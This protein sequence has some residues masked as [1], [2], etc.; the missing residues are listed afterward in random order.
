VDFAK[1]ALD[2][3]R[4]RLR[5]E[6]CPMTQYKHCKVFLPLA[7][8]VLTL[9]GSRMQADPLDPNDFISL[10]PSPFIQA[11]TYTIDTGVIPVLTKPDS[12]TI[13]GVV[14]SDI[15]VFTFADIT[16]SSGITVNVTGPRPLAVLSYKS[17]HMTGG[18]IDVRGSTGGVSSGGSGGPG[19]GGGG[20]SL[21][22][23]GSGL[24]DGFTSIA[25][26]G[27]GGGGFGGSGGTGGGSGGGLGGTPYGNLAAWLEGGSSGGAGGTY[28]GGGGGGERWRSVP[29]MASPSAG[30]FWSMAGTAVLFLPTAAAAAGE[31]CCTE[32]R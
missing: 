6:K 20:N 1:A 25:D 27:G 28:G 8:L 26:D 7:T 17:V 18:T 15:A 21:S 4:G 13:F 31:S 23:K 29:L 22:F 5:K 11:G 30:V 3:H 12:T 32:R 24:G 10:G 2:G 9:W 14:L 16:M 19:G